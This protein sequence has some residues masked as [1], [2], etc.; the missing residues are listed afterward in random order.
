[1]KKHNTSKTS[2]DTFKKYSRL[3]LFYS[4]RVREQMSAEQINFFFT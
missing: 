2:A 1:M 3:N 4:S